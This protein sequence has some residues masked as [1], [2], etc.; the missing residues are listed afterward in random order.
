MADRFQKS[1]QREALRNAASKA[2]IARA[3]ETVMSSRADVEQRMAHVHPDAIHQE[4]QLWQN[5]AGD[6]KAELLLHAEPA[7]DGDE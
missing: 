5:E 1:Q 4:L 6:I 7:G 2:A 3:F